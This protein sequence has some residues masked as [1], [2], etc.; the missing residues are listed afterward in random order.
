MYIFWNVPN[1]LRLCGWLELGTFATGTHPCFKEPIVQH[2][3]SHKAEGTP[4][5]GISA[6]RPPLRTQHARLLYGCITWEVLVHKPDP[7]EL[8]MQLSLGLQLP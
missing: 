4:G 3:L 2:L 7:Q 8:A 5:Q 1:Q 6:D